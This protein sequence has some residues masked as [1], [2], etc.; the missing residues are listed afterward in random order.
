MF[1]SPGPF[2]C[3][4]T[5]VY[6]VA[7]VDVVVV[8]PLHFKSFIMR[9]WWICYTF[10]FLL[11]SPG[12]KNLSVETRADGLLIHFTLQREKG[13]RDVFLSM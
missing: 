9:R 11:P 6:P 7:I 2:I 8:V 13:G 1:F 12:L 3:H 5:A 10:F 4:V